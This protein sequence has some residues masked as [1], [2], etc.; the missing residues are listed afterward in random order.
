MTQHSDMPPDRHNDQPPA[1]PSP[2][3][4]CHATGFIYQGVGFV[5]AVGACCW[6]SFAGRIEGAIDV[7]KVIDT[8]PQVAALSEPATLWHMAAV[9]LTFVGGMVLAV[10]GLGLQHDRPRS[11]PVAKWVTGLMALFY[12]SYFVWALFHPGAGR[13]V[14]AGIMAGVW[15]VAFLL[16]GVSC[17]QLRRHPPRPEEVASTWTPDDEDDLRRAASPRQ[18]DRTSR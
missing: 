9:V 13:A 5:L 14:V 11:G 12:G 3:A 10:L 1:A 7:R 16:A 2:R 18:R 8:S 4:F 15:I 17:E 6:W